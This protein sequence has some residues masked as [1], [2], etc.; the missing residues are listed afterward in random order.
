MAGV[1]EL[2]FNVDTNID[3]VKV[4]GVAQIGL[5]MLHSDPGAAIA[6]FAVLGACLAHREL[7]S[8]YVAL[9]VPGVVIDILWLL[10][11]GNGFSTWLIT[12]VLVAVRL[13]TTYYA[14]DW[15]KASLGGMDQEYLPFGGQAGQ[16]DP[17]R[18]AQPGAGGASSYVPPPPEVPSFG[19]PV[20]SP[21]FAP[22]GMPSDSDEILGAPP[23][24]PSGTLL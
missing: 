21:H 9:A 3:R 10:T 23:K 19:Q 8:L 1:L 4:L 7:M 11:R 15:L 14:W 6:I 5:A 12:L 17:F 13:A 16:R 18:T 24:Q 22:S 2:G 20:A